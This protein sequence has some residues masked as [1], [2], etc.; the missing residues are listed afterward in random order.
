VEWS[1]NMS[2]KLS[3][4]ASAAEIVA[5]VGVIVSLV[6]VGLQIREGN[7]ETRAATIQASLDSEMF[8]QSQFLRNADVWEKI[9]AGLPLSEGEETRRGIVLFNMLMT[10]NENRYHQV[11]SGFLDSELPIP[12]LL[13][14]PFFDT[15]RASG[16]ARARSPEFL[17]FIDRERAI[18]LAK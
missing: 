7:E 17:E 18:A 12:G 2:W 5:A 11:N 6:F 15:W 8:L 3:E 16:G 9:A 4:L 14:S 13:D 10:M 1:K